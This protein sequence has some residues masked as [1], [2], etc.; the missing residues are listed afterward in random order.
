[1]FSYRT[2]SIQDNIKLDTKAMKT[3]FISLNT[4]IS[5]GLFEHANKPS[6][7]TRK[8]AFQN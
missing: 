6:G 7:Y 2:H 4:E 3:A 8:E 1:M 5:G